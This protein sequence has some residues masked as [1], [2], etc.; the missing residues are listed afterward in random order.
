MLTGNLMAIWSELKSLIEGRMD[1]K[2]KL[3]P[4]R[5][6]LLIA[7]SNRLIFALALLM[8]ILIPG[9]FLTFW[10]GSEIAGAVPL[11]TLLVGALGGFVGLQKRV[12]ILSEEELTLLS[13]SWVYTFLSP[14]VGGILSSLTY[15]LFVSGLISGDLFPSFKALQNEASSGIKTLFDIQGQATDYAKLIFWCFLAGY[16]ERFATNIL[17]QFEAAGANL[18]K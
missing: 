11:M 15:V 5:M 18:K 13:K 8:A 14:V 7:V 6:Q 17:S 9:A 1:E 4:E 12:N 3:T 2:P 10:F 16:S